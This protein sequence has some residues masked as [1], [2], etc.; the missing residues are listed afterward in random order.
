[1]LSYHWG[2][3]NG[4]S[5]HDA[6]GYSVSSSGNVNGDGKDDIIIGGSNASPGSKTNADQAY[7][8]FGNTSVTG[9]IELSSLNGYNCSFTINGIA[10]SDNAG[11]SVASVRGCKN[12]KKNYQEGD[13]RQEIHNE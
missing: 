9:S 6:A 2:G 1:M 11:Y 12:Y 4:I 8:V 7:I 10:S 5:A 13:K 3:I